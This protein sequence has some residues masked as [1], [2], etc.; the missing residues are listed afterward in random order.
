LRKLI[1]KVELESFRSGPLDEKNAI[2]SIHAGAGGTESCDW[3][4]MLLRMY[5]RWAERVGFEVD[6]QD[7]QPGEEAGISRATFR[8]VGPRAYGYAKAERG[9]HRRRPGFDAVMV[10]GRTA[11]ADDP[12]LTVRLVP[13]GR[14][15][16]RR[17]VLAPD[18]DLDPKAALFEDA[19]AAPV[20][21]FSRLD[22]AEAAIERLEAAGA[23]VHPVGAE[24]AALELGDVLEVAWE[25]GIRSI[26]CEGGGRLARSLL[27]TGNAHRLYLFV[28]PRT[29]GEAAV[30]AFPEG[31]TL[32]WTDFHPSQTPAAFGA[33]TRIVLDRRQGS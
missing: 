28:A 30:P 26:L 19:E 3:A 20:H 18:A 6:M 15:A 31:E 13:P 16:P 33:D 2:V 14:Q 5:T 17:I 21:V 8:L 1:D 9:V 12:R 29:L 4:D 23:H 32:D 27:G 7:L 22:A 11:R 24:G 25:L 10:G